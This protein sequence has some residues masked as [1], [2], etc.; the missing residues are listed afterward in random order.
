MHVHAINCPYCGAILGHLWEWE[1]DQ[2]ECRGEYECDY[3]KETFILER[4]F[5]VWYTAK[6]DRIA[7][8]RSE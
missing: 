4:N 3:C 8:K 6:K 5:D 2:M 1:K 7:Q